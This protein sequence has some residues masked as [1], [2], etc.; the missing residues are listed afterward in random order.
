[1][2]IFLSYMHTVMVE[3][4]VQ[5]VR[6]LSEVGLDIIE[7]HYALYTAGEMSEEEAKRGAIEAL[8]PLRYSGSEYY[9]IYDYEGTVVLLPPK[10]EREG[11]NFIDLQ[12]ANGVYLVQE[13]IEQARTDHKE[14][15]Y[16][17]SKAGS[18]VPLDK[19][20]VAFGF[21][22]WGWMMG[23]GIY[24]DDV[25]AE[26]KAYMLRILGYALPFVL[27]IGG[28]AFFIVRSISLPLK[29]ITDSMTCLAAGDKSIESK[30]IALDNEIGS[31]ARALETFKENAIKA[32]ALSDE[33]FIEQQK[34]QQRHRQIEE[35]AA[36][37]DQ[38][39]ASG[40]SSVLLSSEQMEKASE[41]LYQLAADTTTQADLAKMSSQN[42][43]SSVQAVAGATEELSASIA[44]ISNNIRT[45]KE[46]SDSVNEGITHANE[47]MKGLVET[48][49]SV[50]EIAEMI[51]QIASQ[52]NLLA[53][54]ATIEA[55]R[56]GEAGKGFAVVANE[57][58]HLAT[59]TAQA[60]EDINTHIQD[61]QL[62]V[63]DATE[64][65]SLVVDKIRSMD[66]VTSSVASSV[67]QQ[68][69]ATQEIAHNVNE[70]VTHVGTVTE[71]IECVTDAIQ[72]TGET[73][74]EVH[75][76][77]RSVNEKTVQ[78]TEMIKTFLD[79]VKAA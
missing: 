66:E 25:A 30:Y 22:P 64:A 68:N 70:V 32:D 57:V 18:D 51:D 6:N 46:I 41:S 12:D 17:F 76:E 34:T 55:A 67:E 4:R 45:A 16:Q 39:V 58:K 8:R 75:N 72:R 74:K 79:D 11:K 38:S 27:I 63:K 50:G 69:V 14:V 62:S 2:N 73:S 48:S 71:S 26:Y 3:D 33:K 15:F 44:E 31:L 40:T 37:F 65:I 21:E 42:A 9:F 56:A 43:L 29:E 61:I 20:A 60:T 7:R 54:N 24:L 59:Q 47:K 19:V 49:K 28:C 77:T 36:S 13:L 10:P 1:M 23:T 52:T 78:L 35:A 5:K 53:L